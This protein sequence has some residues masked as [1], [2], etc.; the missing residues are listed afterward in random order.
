MISSRARIALSLVAAAML[1]S[2]CDTG[3]L[4][5][6]FA[7]APSKSSLLGDR[8]SVLPNEEA[9]APDPT[10]QSVAVQ[11]PAP[12][13]NTEWAQPGGFSDNAPYHLEAPGPLRQIWEQDT[14]KGSDSDSRL[15]APPVVA[16]GH[17]Y[18]LDAE[19]RV[20]AYNEA[21]GRPLW[22][23]RL[24]P[25]GQDSFLHTWTLGMLGENKT[26]DA[27]KGFGGGLAYDDGKL[28]VTTGF[29][30]IFAL[31]PANGRQVWKLHVETPIVNAPVANGGRLYVSTADNHFYALAQSDGRQLWDHRGIPESA[32]ILVSTSAA[33]SGDTVIAPYSS[34]EL[35]ALRVQTGQQ[36]WDELLTQSGNKTAI[37][38]LDDIAGR[39]VIDRDVVY[40]VSHSGTMVAK[41][42]STG[43]RLWQRA[44]GG[45]QTPWA[46]GDWVYVLTIDGQVL[47]LSRKDGKVRW[48]HQLQNLEDMENKASDPIVWAGPVLV[49]DRL[50]LVSSD[51]YAVSLSPYTGQLL[52]RMEIPDGAYI[53]PVVANGTLYIY[54]NDAEL[55]ALR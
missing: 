9:I 10:L 21:D 12:Y 40:A 14:G 1:L 41:K 42:L 16:G 32:G 53:A 52:G 47:C 15:T 13:R 17:I 18:V 36:E 3:P 19:A 38:E 54:T 30:D 43:E 11:L 55:V 45:T 20:L 26:I 24:A 31:S 51:G 28:Y 23:V 49:S 50:V 2:G 29:G 22:S 27:S 35:F 34:G 7:K 8:I 37:S 5:D 46:A 39:P 33:V 4:A 44:I 25:V 6:L 48:M